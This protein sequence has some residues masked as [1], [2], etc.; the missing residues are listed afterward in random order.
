MSKTKSIISNLVNRDSQI[1]KAI[2]VFRALQS[3]YKTSLY[4]KSFF[5]LSIAKIVA[6]FYY[7]VSSI[8]SRRLCKITKLLKLIYI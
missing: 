5:E 2:V 4:I 7:I 1:D 6:N 3:Q 8:F